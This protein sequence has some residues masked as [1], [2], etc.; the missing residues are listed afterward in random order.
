MFKFDASAFSKQLDAAFERKVQEPA[1]EVIRIAVKEVYAKLATEAGYGA[2]YGSPV[3]FANFVNNHKIS[4]NGLDRSYTMTENAKRP[5][6][7]RELR[8]ED[9]AELRNIRLGDTVN[10]SNSVPYAVNLE[11]FGSSKKT[12]RGVYRITTAVVK[13]SLDGKVRAA[14][15]GLSK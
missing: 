3:W 13:M 10:I 14:F 8:G 6:P 11:Y 15:K 4:V 2:G 9:E 12:P 5:L 1:K 7:A